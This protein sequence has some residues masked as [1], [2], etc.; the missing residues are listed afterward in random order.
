MAALFEF[1]KDYCQRYIFAIVKTIGILDMVDILLLTFV[2]YFVYCFIRDRRAGKLLIGL[3]C[4]L[5]LSLLGE[6]FDLPATSFVFNDFRQIGMIAVLILFQP[7]L[8]GA[9]EKVGGT[10]LSSIRSMTSDSRELALVNAEIDAVCTAASDLSRDKVGA[11]I[12][13]ERSTKLGEYVKSGV[14][15]DATISPYILRNI[16]FNKAPLHDGAV[17]IRAGRICA[18]GCFLP[19]STQDD[20][21]KELGTRH[22]AALGLSE[23]SDAI[24]IVVSEENGIISMAVDG[25]LERNYNYN[26]LKQALNRLL[27]PQGQGEN[28]KKRKKKARSSKQK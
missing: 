10:P 26:S 18:A 9:L 8:R 22:R 12:A 25:N 23:M 7:E 24:V 17:I 6:F 4:V 15:I 28:G 1:L 27:I 14:F 16:F 19:L 2:L 3:G 11:L 21:N 20:L 13:I 5:C